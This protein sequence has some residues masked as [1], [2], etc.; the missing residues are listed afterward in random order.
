[1]SAQHLEQPQE[2]VQRVA[3]TQQQTSWLEQSRTPR[4][5]NQLT[6]LVTELCES[7]SA[8]GIAG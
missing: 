3:A 5:F 6:T 4:P 2:P 8:K 1:M 7:D